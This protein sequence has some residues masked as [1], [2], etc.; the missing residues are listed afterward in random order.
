[1]NPVRMRTGF[2]RGREHLRYGA[3]SSVAEGR[4]AIALSIGGAAKVYE[5]REPNEDAVG[6]AEGPGGIV[7]AVA[8]GHD[9][10]AAA[11]LAV[12]RLLEDGATRW[13]GPAPLRLGESWADEAAE[14]LLELNTAILDAAARGG[15]AEARTTLAFALVRPDQDLLAFASLGDSHI[16][17]VGATEVVDLADRNTQRVWFLGFPSET[18]WSLRDR[19]VAGCERLA[20]TRALVL[21]SDGVSERGIGIDHP[22]ACV[23]ECAASALQAASELRALELARGVGEQA[24]AAQRRQRSGDNVAIASIWLQKDAPNSR[25]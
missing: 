25:S 23:A 20:G 18:T 15:N 12:Q 17:H 9:G 4:C 6:F 2:L 19:I 5:H 1:M 11:E 21:A 24:L 7:A 13:T 3:I 22:E 16:F 8:D 14:I 10:G